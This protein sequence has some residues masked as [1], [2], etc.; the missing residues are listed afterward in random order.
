MAKNPK[1]SVIDAINKFSQRKL[2][3]GKPKESRKHYEKPEKEVEKACLEWMRTQGWSVN[4]FEAKATFDPRRQRYISQSMKAGTCDCM[5]NTSEGVSVAVEFKAPGAI[6]SFNSP[7]RI[8]QKQ[9]IINKILTNCFA[10]VVD[11]VEKL[12]TIYKQWQ[13]LRAD[14]EAARSYLL[15]A[16]PKVSEKNVQDTLFDN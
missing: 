15:K 3:E 1:Q 7:K 12:E 10:C 5:G 6:S 16:L 9:F 14:G 2:D 13:F 11:S 8:K 4:I